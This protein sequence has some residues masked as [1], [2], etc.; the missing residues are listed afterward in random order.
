MAGAS[1]AMKHLKPPSSFHLHCIS[2]I[3]GYFRTFIV[4]L[5]YEPKTYSYNEY[6]KRITCKQSAITYSFRKAMLG[7]LWPQILQLYQNLIIITFF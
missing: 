1:R 4:V 3:N 7:P 6:E 5:A 2:L